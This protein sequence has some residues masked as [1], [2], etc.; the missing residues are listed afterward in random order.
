MKVVTVSRL[1][2]DD[3]KQRRQNMGVTNTGVR[4]FTV[5]KSGS[6]QNMAPRVNKDS[7]PNML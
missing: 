7:T 2:L 1:T 3:T 6:T 4:Q 5:D